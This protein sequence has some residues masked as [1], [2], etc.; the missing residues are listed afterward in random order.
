M[1]WTVH[2]G[3]AL[4]T[5]LDAERPNVPLAAR[6]SALCSGVGV[7]VGGVYLR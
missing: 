4:A 7:G 2:E 6:A 1:T 3:D 5:L